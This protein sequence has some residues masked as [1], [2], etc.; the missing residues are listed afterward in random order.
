M[1]ISKE[2]L[3][4]CALDFNVKISDEKIEKFDIYA[5][6]LVSYNKKVNLTSI[7][8][9][10]DI[11]IKH[12][13]D[14]L[15]FIKFSGIKKGNNLADVGTGA[16]FPGIPVLIAMSDI[17]LTLIDAVNKKLEFLR[18]LT[19]ELDLEADIVHIRAED[20]GK[21]PEYREKFDYTTARAVAQLRILSEFC[22]PLT[23][24]SG[25]FCAMKGTISD[26]EKKYGINSF[27]KMGGKISDDIFYR[28]HNGDERNIIIS[29]KVAE[30]PVK[31]PR[32]MSKISKKPL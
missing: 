6:S 32:S 19:K 3:K 5:S 14:S 12:F 28:I 13:G 4:L 2:L 9:P 1:F 8:D 16:G 22:L 15:A 20:A 23:K 21:S 29:E 30:T 17:Q 26:E 25:K 10:D 7:T 11:V 18:F 31:Y 24:I 27:E